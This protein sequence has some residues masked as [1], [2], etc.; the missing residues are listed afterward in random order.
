MRIVSSS[1]VLAAFVLA[2]AS[3]VVIAQGG[4]PVTVEQHAATM[5]IVQQN[6][7]AAN[8]AL[9]GGDAAAAAP[10][11]E[12]LVAAFTT[13][14]MFYTQRNKPDA[15]KLAQTAKTGAQD[16]VAALKAGDTMKAQ[17]SLGNTQGTCKQC[18]GMYREGDA[19]TGYKFNAASGITPP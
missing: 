8:K 17:M 9:K 7:G 6:M 18:H 16:V 19:Q 11:A 1:I 15:I 5:K 2:S 10:A 12:A 4:K 14:E 3:T 13:I